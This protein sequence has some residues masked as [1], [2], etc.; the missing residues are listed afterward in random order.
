MRND[1]RMMDSVIVIFIL[2]L[3]L[4]WAGKAWS[5]EVVDVD[6]LADAIYKAEGSITNPYGIMRD[7]CHAGAEAQCRKGC[8]QTINKWKERLKYSDVEGFLRQFAEVYAPTRNASNDPM[9]LNKNWYKN[10][11]HFYRKCA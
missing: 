6:R 10:V 4:I 2:A 5:Y 8:I 9:G 7:Y 1:N 11:L 3:A